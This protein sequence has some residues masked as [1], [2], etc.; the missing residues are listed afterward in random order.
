MT[1]SF[2]TPD[3]PAPRNVR[4]LITTR[5]GGVSDPPFQ[6][7]NLG[8][9][10]GDEAARVARNRMLLREHLPAEP[11]WLAQ[12]HGSNVVNAHDCAGVPRAD[13]SWTDRAGVVCAVLI[14]DCLPVLFCDRA[15]SAVA[16]AHA[17]WRG[18]ATGV[19]ERTVEAMALPG[20][21]LLAYLG[22][23][24]SADAFEVGQEVYDAFV[25]RDA[26]ASIAFRHRGNG[27]YLAD[28]YALA[29]LRLRAV[30][31]MPTYGGNFCTLNDSERFY[32]YRRDHSTGR[33]AALI[34]MD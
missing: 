34:W 33:M 9:Q 6:S 28:L 15:G 25:L 29:R 4:A 22:P 7:L 5:R 18:L 12:E 11:K 32:S 1:S 31:V 30:G 27:K 17:G 8:T 21:D 2:I 3:W 23:A 26:S 20:G 19:I 13:A 14:A 10:A 16:I 24:I